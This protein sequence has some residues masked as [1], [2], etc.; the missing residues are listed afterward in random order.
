MAVNDLTLQVRHMQQAYDATAGQP[1]EHTY[2]LYLTCVNG[3]RK[4]P[5]PGHRK[6]PTSGE[7][8]AEPC[9]GHEAVAPGGETSRAAPGRMALERS[10]WRRMR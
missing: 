10:A 7:G 3:H 4:C 6:C 2:Y 5:T 8:G 1:G 9:G